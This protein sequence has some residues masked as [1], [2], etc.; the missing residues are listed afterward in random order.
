MRRTTWVAAIGLAVL[1]V[2]TP[3]FAAEDQPSGWEFDVV[4]YLW[5]PG[6]FQNLQVR[7]R[8]FSQTTTVGDGL[9]LFFHGDAFA[10]PSAFLE[11]RYDRW[12]VCTDSFFAFINV[13]GRERIPTRIG[14]LTV[15]ASSNQTA[16]LIDIAA[17]YRLGEWSLPDRQRPVWLGVYLGTRYAHLGVDLSASVA[18][19]RIQRSASASSVFNTALPLIGVR[20][21]V[22]LLD[23][24][25]LDFRGDIGGLPSKNS[26]TWGL[27]GELR[28]Y[29]GWAPL[30]TKTWLGAG[31]RVVG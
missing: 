21:E 12:S 30:E 11:A 23:P 17:A 16:A 27:V 9:K 2:T 29:M 6:T 31:Y 24:L 15:G 13:N 3:T 28:Y 19:R 26:L 10:L 5:F 22:P 4:P 25:T 8:H 18:F 1:V 14:T 20:W 7:G